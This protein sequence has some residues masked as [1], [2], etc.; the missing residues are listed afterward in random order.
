MSVIYR[1]CLRIYRTSVE[2]L[3]Q[4][5]EHPPGGGLSLPIVCW[6]W[7][8]S[9][10]RVGCM[11]WA[12]KN[13]KQQTTNDKQQTTNNDVPRN[14]WI[15]MDSQDFPH[16]FNGFHLNFTEH[17]QARAHVLGSNSPLR[18]DFDPLW[19]PKMCINIYVDARFEPTTPAKT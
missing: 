9:L 12:A 4:S 13:W 10:P 19:D 6:M 15:F 16:N 3:S 2:Q 1:N 11:Q 5:L 18:H 17:R 7:G 14:P 8:L